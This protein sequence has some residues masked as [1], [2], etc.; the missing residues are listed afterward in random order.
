MVTTPCY[1]SATSK[2][3]NASLARPPQKPKQLPQ[4]QQPRDFGQNHHRDTPSNTSIILNQG[5]R[6]PP[7]RQR[8]C[9]R[10]Q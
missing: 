3:V 9:Q 2:L 10:S 1:K 8:P 6:Q 5:S 7:D 4:R